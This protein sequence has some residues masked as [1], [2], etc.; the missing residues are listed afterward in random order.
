MWSD[1]TKNE[2]NIKWA[3]DLWNAVQPFV[4]GGVYVNFMMTEGADRVMAAY[5]KK[6]Y[7]RL[8]TLKNKYDPMNLFTCNF[9]CYLRNSSSERLC[10]FKVIGSRSPVSHWT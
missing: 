10:D 6:K 1:V 8:V 9:L 2:E 3:R 7:E 4:T 5:G